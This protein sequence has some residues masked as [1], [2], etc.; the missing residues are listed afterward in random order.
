MKG[1]VYIYT[2]TSAVNIYD[3][4]FS[5]Q[6][7]YRFR[8]HLLFWTAWTLYFAFTYL[9]PTYWVPAWDLNG[10]M[11]QIEQYGVFISCLRILMN[12]ILMTV[13][14]MGLVYGIFYFIL[15]R[16]LSNKN[17][18]ITTALLML[19]ILIVACFNYLNFLLIFSISTQMGYFDKMPPMSFIIP[20]WARQ[21]IFN[22]PAVVG[23]AVAIKLLKHWYLKQKETE[24]LIREKIN[25]ELQVLK[26]QVH[27]HFLFNT[28]N[29]IYSFSL[30]GSPKAPGLIKKLSALLNYILNECNTTEV[31]LEKELTMLKD[32]IAIE[33]IRYGDSLSLSQ[34]FHGDAAGKM[35]SPLLLIPFVENSFKHGASRM[36]THPWVKLNLTIEQ[37]SLEFKISNSKPGLKNDADG[38]KGIGLNNA[39]KRLQLLYPG[40]HQLSISENDVSYEVYMKINFRTSA[41]KK[42][43]VRITP[44]TASYGV[45]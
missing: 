22:Y 7:K 9:V 31:A 42:K 40:A 37:D 39:K 12:S 4:I 1:D 16:Y 13:V 43:K 5:D 14:E 44:E 26:S 28:I 18:L 20:L 45:A 41:Q 38:K 25:A 34:Q 29:N 6:R 32:Y 21:I 3:F 36:L 35:I 2:S 11:P 30:N 23:F 27:P 15:P 24:E 10:R 33:Q 19:L 17:R 8:R